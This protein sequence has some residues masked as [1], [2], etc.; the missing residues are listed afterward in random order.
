MNQ[1]IVE[2]TPTMS[3]QEATETNTL[4]QAHH[5]L[6]LAE[7]DGIIAQLRVQLATKKVQVVQL[8]VH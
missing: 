5:Q 1:P 6:Q 2:I 7:K 4:M 8:Q 3:V